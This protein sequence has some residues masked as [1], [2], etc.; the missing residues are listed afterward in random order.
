MKK[1]LLL[2]ALT[3]STVA[4]ASSDVSTTM[5]I[6]AIIVKPL[7]V[8]HNGD[9]NFGVIAQ[10]QDAW[11][12]GKQFKVE[13]NPGQSI[14]FTINGKTLN[15]YNEVRINNAE[16]TSSVPIWLENRQ[17]TSGSLYSPTIGED[18]TFIYSFNAKLVPGTASG[19]HTGALVVSVKYN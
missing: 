17:V 10:N 14:S 8:S 4:L 18:G 11:V 16:G 13:G 19:L 7:T 15:D 6:N 9:M 3:L 5:N 2:L 1:I 12:Y